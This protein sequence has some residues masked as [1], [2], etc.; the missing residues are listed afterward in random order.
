VAISRET[1]EIFTPLAHRL[2]MYTFKSELAD[3]SFSYLFPE[4]HKTLQRYIDGKRAMHE[5][6]LAAAEAKIRHTIADDPWLRQTVRRVAIEGRTKSI[7]STWRK[8]QRRGCRVEEVHDLLAMRIILDLDDSLAPPHHYTGGV[9]GGARAEEPVSESSLCYHVL[10]KVHSCWTPMPG[11]LKDYISTPKP[12]GYRSLHTTVLMGAG[13]HENGAQPLEVQIRTTS[14]HRI[15]EKGAAAHWAYEERKNDPEVSHQPWQQAIR[16]WQVERQ[17]PHEF[18]SVVRQELLSTRV[19]V[20][21]DAGRILNLA[22]GATLADAAA[23]LE[24]PVGADHGAFLCSHNLCETASLDTKL[25]N[26][27]IVC[28]SAKNVA[29]AQ[30]ESVRLNDLATPRQELVESR[31]WGRESE[32]GGERDSREGLVTP[33]QQ[34]TE[35]MDTSVVVFVRDVP[36]T[37][38]A[39]TEAVTQHSLTIYE[40]A[41]RVRPS[42]S[43]SSEEAVGAFQFRVQLASEAQLAELIVGLEVL[44]AVV[45]V[46]H[47]SMQSMLSDEDRD[48]GRFWQYACR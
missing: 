34:A 30:A 23:M 40:V 26:G 8:M 27:D 12:N 24:V 21:T 42:S 15:A 1:L 16:S 47:D 13:V 33:T 14:M 43:T 35:P 2:G 39:L 36:G 45:C 22:H 11:T 28:F 37:L 18:M 17:C 6:S 46:R 32:G 44:S 19:F 31:L 7:H 41:S 29:A 10:G 3:L 48:P 5:T 20:F 9:A 38:L 25:S 4:S